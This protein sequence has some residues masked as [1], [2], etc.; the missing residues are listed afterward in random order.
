MSVR[1][2]TNRAVVLDG[3]HIAARS[4]INVRISESR[5]DELVELEC[6]TC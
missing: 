6:G 2:A 4:T 1:V 5:T 3:D